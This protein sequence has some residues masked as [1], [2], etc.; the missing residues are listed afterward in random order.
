V[1]AGTQLVYPSS[2]TRTCA[3]L[4]AGLGLIAASVVV[5]R[6]FDPVSSI[7][8]PP[9]PLHWLTGL[10]CPGC[11][12]LRAFHQLLHGN[13]GNAFAFNPFAVLAL[14]F[15]AYGGLSYV[16]FRMRGRHLPRVFL[17][18]GWIWTLGLAIVVFGIARNI[19]MYPFSLLAPGAMLAR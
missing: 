15:L 14:P 18:A 16:V 9:C 6:F 2:P 17:P 5:L 19:P 12:S 7:L 4:L 3:E 13:L 1:S 10:Y 8:F 11:G